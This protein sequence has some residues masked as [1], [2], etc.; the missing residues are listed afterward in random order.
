MAKVLGLDLGTNSIG[1]AIVEQ[2]D[3]GYTLLD[4]GVDIFQEGV[5]REKNNEK[6]AVQD[7]T[8]ARALRRH[9]FRRRL[10]KIE[11][12]KVLVKEDMCPALTDEQ[13]SAWQKKKQYP[14]DEEFLAW[15]RT[16]DNTDKNPYHDR[17]SALTQKLDLNNRQDRHTLGRALYHLAQRRGFLS[18][19]K[20]TTDPNESGKVKDS[21]K[22]LSEE[23]NTAGCSYL[24]EYFYMLYRKKGKIRTKYTSRNEHY[25]AEFNAICEKQNLPQQLTRALHR[26]IFYQRPLKSQKGL[27][28]RC[29]FEKSKSRCPMSHP[30]F[31]EFRMLSFI[32]NIRVTGPDDSAPRPLNESERQKILPLFMRKSKPHFDFE[33]IAR[34]LA[35][36][37]QYACKGDAIQ[38]PYRFNFFKSHSVSGCPVTAGLSS[39]FG[40]DY[41]SE[42]CSL[43]RKA[44]GKTADRIIDDVWHVL[45]SFDD[46]QKLREWAQNN[47][48]LSD[49]EAEKFADIRP[50]QGYAMLSL[51]AIDKMLPH[52]RTGMRYDEAVFV[53]NL[54]AVLPADVWVDKAVLNEIEKD[55]ADILQNYVRNPYDR[56]DSKERRISD[57][58][59]GQG[60][61]DSR[62]GHLYHPSMIET[63]HK[64]EPNADGIMQLGDPRTPAVRNPMAMRAL[65]RLRILLNKL[66]QEG[67]IDRDTKI[68]I[69]FARELNDA[70]MRGAIYKFQRE[71]EK[72]N[73][74]Y[75]DE[76][77]KLYKEA[78]G[79]D[80]EPTDDD[81][82]K[83]KLWEEQ[84]H[85]CLYTGTEIGI[86]GFIG[87]DTRY[88]IEHTVP[89]SRGGD[90]S[91][92]NKTLCEKR[93][94]RETKRAKLPS[95]LNEHAAI[96][97]RIED[98]GWKEKIA[99]LQKQ[100]EGTKVRS[101]NATTKDK[102]DAAIQDRHFLEM[103]RK[104]W[105]DK[106]ERFT[107]TEV[108]DG[109]SLRQGVDI[110]IIGK[111]AR[112]YLQ[113]VFDRIYTVK[114]STTAA[115][116][117]MWGLQSEYTV[118][119]R[120]NHTHHCM[121]A[122]TIACIGRKE[123]DAW[124]QFEDDEDKHEWYGTARPQFQKPWPTFTEDV[125]AIS[126]R[127]LISHHTADNMP[128]QSRK[129]LRI[130]GKVQYG[131]DGAPL[132]VQGD[133]ARGSLHKDT[134]YGAIEREGEIKYVVRKSLDSL[135]ESD[136][137][138][139]VDDAVRQKIRDAVAEKGFKE[140]TADTIWMNEQKGIPIRKVRIFATSITQPIH[141]KKH[142]DLSTKE[143][144]Q[145]YHVAND[146][147]YCMAIY[148]GT[149]KKGKPKRSF[150][151]VSNIE[152]AAYFKRSADRTARPDLV[153][154]SDKDGF[155]L[156]YILK[157]GTM[158][159][160]Y[161][162]SPAE[163]HECSEQE[164]AKR[165][166]KITTMS[167]MTL[168]RENGK[169]DRYGVLVLRHHQ[170]ARPATELKE[171][172]GIW[173]TGEE[174]RPLIKLY[175]TQLNAYV[176]GYDFELSVTGKIAFKHR[177]P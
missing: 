152:A 131:K 4:K 82:L 157:T 161:E 170:E 47:L 61:D 120:D 105:A 92:A 159:L 110:G 14:M 43:Y 176:E 174:Y 20:D 70:N 163:L 30:R 39:I 172:N 103:K 101:R 124:A 21:I 19:R 117:K 88:D 18:N 81:I 40:D 137:D 112:L 77:R 164:L 87:T 22:G 135:Q 6:P 62:T 52:L 149:D 123:Y 93:F 102:K 45:F 67:S 33:E 173:K 28:G 113:T 42:I 16:C 89:R 83:Y 119:S 69:E 144:K 115:F 46:E 139:I 148:E 128:K 126:D 177:Q 154:Q 58:L 2:N 99:D 3:C 107:I 9:Y 96:M 162:N 130:R 57:Y 116:R 75:A 59:R 91:Q 80:I 7:R 12:L 29:T 35:G 100:I 132:Y 24:G 94:N 38:A 10:R 74:E 136:I 27:V 167:S 118:K 138:K 31:E 90:D 32:N 37:G 44:E 133:T 106:Y 95:E 168:K 72:K 71:N 36:K 65:F 166:Y 156:K 84:N 145:E 48:Q 64:A 109:F 151:M 147:N 55:I 143:Y 11:L 160:F 85:K 1:W 86:T 171:K 56:F 169:I 98:L 150:E 97:A 76:I 15:Q 53:A 175:H 153:P 34:K 26:A 146:S 63:Y 129:K 79:R 5:A 155:P 8:N 127:L 121:D 23:M 140:A 125:K 73:K 41:K 25:L 17:F 108:P 51:N 134:F 111:Y 104:Y 122:I 78:T 141:L 158:V 60:I 68:N 50:P 49:T 66:L 142:R 165:L 54:K 13:L 114:G